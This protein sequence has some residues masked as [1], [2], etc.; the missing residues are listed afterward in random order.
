MEI[1]L[2]SATT[3]R[4]VKWYYLFVR[5]VG[6][7]SQSIWYPTNPAALRRYPVARERLRECP[8]RKKNCASFHIRSSWLALPLETSGAGE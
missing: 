8:L 4:N 2:L 7:E 3:E 6:V 5:L 1:R